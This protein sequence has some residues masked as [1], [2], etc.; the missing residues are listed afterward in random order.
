M[1]I[2]IIDVFRKSVTEDYLLAA[3]DAAKWIKNT[4]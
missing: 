3:V 4:K 1:A 2:K